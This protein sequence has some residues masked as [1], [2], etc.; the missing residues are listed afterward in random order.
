MNLD[1]FAGQI[2]RDMDL[3]VQKSHVPTKVD[4]VCFT[5]TTKIRILTTFC[6]VVGY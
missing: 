2:M 6:T 5:F 1:D 4:V 3:Q